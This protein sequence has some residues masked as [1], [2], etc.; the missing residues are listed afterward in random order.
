MRRF[1]QKQSFR[2]NFHAFLLLLPSL[3]FLLLFTFY[4]IGQTIFHSLFKSD[5]STPEPLFVG[6][7]NFKRL[8]EDD[9]FWKVLMNNIWFA[10]GTIPTTIIIGLLMAVVVNKHIVGRSWIRTFLFYPAV[11]P[12]I[13]IANIWL[14]IYT[15]NF[16]LLNYVLNM[17]GIGSVDLLAHSNTVMFA[18]IVMVIW[19]EAGFFMIF[20]LAGL[21]NISEELY[22]AAKI[23]GSSRWTT[24]TRI[25]IPLLMPTTLFVSIL[26]L[27]N[28]FKLVDHLVVMTQGGP[29]NA[30]NLLL[31]YIY[32]TVFKYWDMGY[33]A[34]L[35]TILL[36]IMMIIASVQFL[37]MEKR[38]HYN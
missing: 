12:A 13:A 36:L 10:I 19:K 20:F 29:N 14:Y 4:P 9:I 21:Q 34:T 18:M 35:T 26:A 3:V 1:Y 24:F 22:D 15:P 8:S 37:F 30:S 38:I 16:G 25:T 31:Y 33:G 28:A 7:E 27:T 5:L 17:V 32:E 23:D 11:I 6:L 2:I